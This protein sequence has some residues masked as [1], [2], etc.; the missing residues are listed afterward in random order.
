MNARESTVNKRKHFEKF[1][2]IFIKS[3]N[4]MTQK[5]NIVYCNLQVKCKKYKKLNV[6]ILK[7]I[8][9]TSL[10]LFL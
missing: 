8:F 7:I 10:M 9:K 1:Y 6:H 3:F 2:T 5:I 4:L